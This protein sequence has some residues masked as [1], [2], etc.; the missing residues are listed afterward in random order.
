MIQ[1]TVEDAENP[2]SPLWQ[3]KSQVKVAVL[4]LLANLVDNTEILK[5][6]LDPEIQGPATLF[7]ALMKESGS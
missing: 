1:V 2:D 5:R 6:V 3:H 7:M 4:G